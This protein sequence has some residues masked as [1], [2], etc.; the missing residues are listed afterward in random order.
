MWKS[1]IE[2]LGGE[3]RPDFPLST[4]A[5]ISHG[6]AA[7]AIRKSCESVLTNYRKTSVSTI[8]LTCVTI[9]EATAA[10]ASRVHRPSIPLCKHNAGRVPRVLEVY[11]LHYRR[12]RPPREDRG[13][14]PR[15]RRRRG[16]QKRQKEEREMITVCCLLFVLTKPTSLN[17]LSYYL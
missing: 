15:R 10:D 9:D 12:R 4:L 17:K 7:G 14:P 16:R 8:Y 3:L 13:G 6:F 11:R 1:F 5:H 2:E